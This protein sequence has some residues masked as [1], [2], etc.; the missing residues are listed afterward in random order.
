MKNHGRTKGD[1]QSL[2]Q[3]CGS[4]GAE[5]QHRLTAYAIDSL[6]YA[7]FCDECRKADDEYYMER[8]EEYRN[9]QGV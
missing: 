6:N 2:C 7:T 1:K 9:S 3:A 8:W 5:M 4:N